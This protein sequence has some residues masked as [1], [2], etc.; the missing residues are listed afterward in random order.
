ML[1][2]IEIEVKDETLQQILD[3]ADKGVNMEEIA[4][5]VSANIQLKIKQEA[6]KLFLDVLK[7]SGMSLSDFVKE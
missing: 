1:I 7:A 4:S 6:V 2:K 5:A 3:N